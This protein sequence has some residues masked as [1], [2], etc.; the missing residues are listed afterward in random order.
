MYRFHIPAVTLEVRVTMKM[1]IM[2]N[3]ELLI[4]VTA[5]ASVTGTEMAMV[6]QDTVM[7]MEQ[8]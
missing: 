8:M 6:L 4:T 5:T 3:M 2:E 7:V 1:A